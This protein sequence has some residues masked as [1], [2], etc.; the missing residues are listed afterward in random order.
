MA[1]MTRS[2]VAAAAILWCASA[3]AQVVGG[4]GVSVSGA[5]TAGHIATFL[6]KF[7]IQDGGAAPSSGFPITLGSTSIA[8]S[9]TTTA[10]TGLSVNGVT[11]AGSG[12]LNI[13][14][15]GTLGTAAFQNTG[16]SGAN[17]PLLNGANTFS[18]TT[19]ISSASFGL[20][21]NFSAPAWTTAGIRYANT[22]ATITDTTSSGTVATAYTDLF[23]GNTIAASSATTFTN[24]YAAYIKAPVTGTNVTFTNKYALGTDSLSVLGPL[25]FLQNNTA[26]A[27]QSSAD[28]N[29]G[30]GSISGDPT[31]WRSST[32]ILRAN[33]TQI[34]LAAPLGFGSTTSSSDILL[35]R[36]AAGILAQR[37]GVSAQTLRVYNTFTD[38]SNYERG[39]FDW[40]GSSNVL[41]IG[42]EKAGTGSTRGMRFLTGGT[43]AATIGTDQSFTLAGQL[44]V[45]AMTQTS[46]AQSGTMCYNSGTGAVTY[47]ATLGCLA[48][49]L[50]FKRDW[51]NLDRSNVLSQL[52]RMDVGSFYYNYE[53]APSGE[54]I[55][56]SAENMAGIE[57]RLVSYGPDGK[58]RG[59]RY[60][61][62]VAFM[63]AVGQA[64]QEQMTR[65]DR[66]LSALEARQ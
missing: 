15:A 55:G 2:F 45:T 51:Q 20:S 48:S 12:T 50:A 56:L 40:Q 43:L 36:D 24:Y 16:T 11:L 59:V 19:T 17:V 27:L 62:G 10:V 37:N 6:N 41:S 49:S 7:T 8:A 53:G 38:A 32:S 3:S 52:M 22:A 65:M 57:P 18:G 21:G 46:A 5:V 9:S 13:G 34:A 14:P 29:S 39:I 4:G 26:P 23:G 42:T 47:D 63:V 1:W 31:I 64:Q 33:T 66:R 60:Q 28:V 25:T 61:N 44:L 35:Q 30:F 58:L 54:Q